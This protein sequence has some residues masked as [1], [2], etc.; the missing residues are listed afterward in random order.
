MKYCLPVVLGLFLCGVVTAQ[1]HS[2]P[3]KRSQQL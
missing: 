1:D 2:A 3:L